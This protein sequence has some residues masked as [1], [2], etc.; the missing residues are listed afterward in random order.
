MLRPSA[1][2]LLA[3][4]LM[5]SAAQAAPS[6]IDGILSPGEYGAI[7]ASV[8]YDP[9]APDSNFGAPTNAS[10]YVAYDIYL[11]ASGGFYQGLLAAHPGQGGGKAGTF[12][13]L[14]LDLNPSAADGSD[15]G[16][17]LGV[18]TADAFIPG[19]SGSVL[20]PEIFTVSSLDGDTFEFA[21]PY[22]DLTGPIAG[23]NYYPG[24]TF[25][26]AGDPVVLRLSQSFGYSV[27]GGPTY[28]INRLGSVTLTATAVPEPIS[29]ALL[30]TGLAGLGL[31]RRKRA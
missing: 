27:A 24:Q 22:A 15:L 13:N 5:T 9:A 29:A 30:A 7:S 11:K 19:T 8:S 6:G 2:L 12:A 21:I 1:T 28:G 16:F 31:L 26:G 4:V 17:E 3:G 14:Y 20:T 23:L 25:P 10:K 18:G